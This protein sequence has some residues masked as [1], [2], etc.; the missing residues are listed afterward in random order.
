MKSRPSVELTWFSPVTKP[1]SID[2]AA[3]ESN[4]TLRAWALNLWNAN[5]TGES[6]CEIADPDLGSIPPNNGSRQVL[7]RSRSTVSLIYH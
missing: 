3:I 5:R 7:I 6:K 4:E 1:P 2:S